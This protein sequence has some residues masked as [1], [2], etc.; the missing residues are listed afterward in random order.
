MSN[1]TTNPQLI[2]KKENK[3]TGSISSSWTDTNYAAAGSVN[4][5]YQSIS[6][7]TKEIYPIGS[8]FCYSSNTNPA[9][10]LGYGTWKL[11]SKKFQKRWITLTAADW[12]PSADVSFSSGGLMLSGDNLILRLV[13]IPNVV[14]NDST[15]TLG[16]INLSNYGFGS[17]Y[18]GHVKGKAQSDGGQATVVYTISAAGTIEVFDSLAYPS[19]A[20]SYST[21]SS[22]Y[23]MHYTTPDSLSAMPDNYCDRFY[24]E[25]TA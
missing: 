10:A 12:T 8:V 22:F 14:L 9:I 16:T 13:L 6:Q 7:K 23:I 2:E 5:L 3:V 17:T 20:H 21:G 19:K 15:T 4:N 11:V 25:R 24:F 1:L 18:Y